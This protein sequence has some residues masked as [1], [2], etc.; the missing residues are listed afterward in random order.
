MWHAAPNFA[1]K[2]LHR[3]LSHK[4]GLENIARKRS[5]TEFAYWDQILKQ[6]D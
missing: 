4:K 2:N 3:C 1:E 5:S 6:I